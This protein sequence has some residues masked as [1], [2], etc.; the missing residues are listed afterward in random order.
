[1]WV[2]RKSRNKLRKS[3]MGNKDAEAEHLRNAGALRR[4]A[5]P[6][7]SRM[8][9]PTRTKPA[10]EHQATTMEQLPPGITFKGTCPQCGRTV[11]GS[12]L[13][14]PTIS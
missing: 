5:S 10:R 8:T 4:I 7:C 2:H 14:L 1:M 12:P 11:R 13:L 9:D 3:D 6:Q